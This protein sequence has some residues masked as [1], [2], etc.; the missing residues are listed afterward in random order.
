MTFFDLVNISERHIELVNPTTPEKVIQLGEVLGLR[1]GSRVLDFGC[2]YG[3]A[4]VLWAERFGIRGVGIDVREH[5]C[6]RARQKVADH[7]L[8]GRIEIVCANAA[9]YVFE[10]NGFDAATCLGASFIWGGFGQTVQAMRRA[11]TPTGRLAIGEVHWLR[12]GVPPQYAARNPNFHQENDLVQI[13]RGEGFHL[14]Y[15]I[16]SSHDDWDRYQSDN[17]RG[18]LAWLD[19][20]PHHPERK[21]VEAHLQAAQD[22]YRRYGREY[23][24]WAMYALAP[25]R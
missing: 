12:D 7:G 2:G 23:V 25:R 10:E 3:E 1:A 17:W 14:G 20:N 6:A 19:E 13:A 8:S 21:Q 4:L 5:A 24:G 15:V 18:W 11:I 9:E 22:D 16:R